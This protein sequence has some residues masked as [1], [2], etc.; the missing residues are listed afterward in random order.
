MDIYSK[1]K[2]LIRLVTGLSA[3]NLLVLSFLA[4]NILV[5]KRGISFTDK[6]ESSNVEV[7]AILKE[8]LA[9]SDEQEV[10]VKNLREDFY[11]KERKL[12]SLIRDKRDSMNL[13]MFNQNTNDTLLY[14]LAHEVAANEE[15]MEWLRIDQAKSF[16]AI[17]TPDQQVKFEG[18]VKEIKDYFRPDNK[19]RKRND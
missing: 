4:W 1:N 15:Q 12:S 6:K 16:K 19:K 8:A 13:I 7:H 17:C 14:R 2:L 11:S 10:A 9:L 5:Q 3:I 18:L